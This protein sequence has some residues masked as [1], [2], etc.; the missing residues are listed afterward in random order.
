MG[1]SGLDKEEDVGREILCQV[2]EQG[3]NELLDLLFLSK[4]KAG[5]E[6]MKNNPSAFQQELSLLG[7]EDWEKS[8]TKG[9]KSK[10]GNVE[11]PG[12]KTPGGRSSPPRSAMMKA[13]IKER[14]GP[15]RI[16]E[17]EFVNTMEE[18][19]GRKLTFMSTWVNMGSF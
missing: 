10:E 9:L 2:T 1:K 18:E 5:L 4:E 14:G 12:S 11:S 3:I 16:S 19:G 8:P 13:E 17:D 15:G 6:A 7:D